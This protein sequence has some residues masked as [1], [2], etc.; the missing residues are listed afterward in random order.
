[1]CKKHG[2]RIVEIEK[3][4]YY[5]ELLE[6]FPISIEL[7]NGVWTV[8]GQKVVIEEEDDGNGSGKKNKKKKEKEIIKKNTTDEEEGLK[9]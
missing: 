2:Q 6:V 8:T 3:S 9:W 5:S 7:S 4:N 1:M